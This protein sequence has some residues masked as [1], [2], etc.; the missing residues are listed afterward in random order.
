M[1]R[2]T[3]LTFVII[4]AA[5]YI[6]FMTMDLLPYSGSTIIIKYIG[7]LLCLL[8]S[9]LCAFRGGER[10]IP[11]AL[12]FTAIADIFLL[13]I[14]NY[15]TVGILFF[16]VVQSIYLFYLFKETGKI[17]IP[18]RIVCLILAVLI[19]W[20]TGLF[21]GQNLV[22]GIYFSMI[23]VNMVMSWTYGKNVPRLFALGLTLFVCC[24][25]CV[26]LYNLYWLLPDGLYAFTR[27][28]MWMF[29]LPSQVLIALSMIK[30]KRQDER[31]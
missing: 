10:L 5:L 27:I 11:I 18:V 19:L 3:I 7:I 12:I 22:A 24:D 28:G 21:N 20:L 14:D 13:V 30:G 6:V 4:E 29:Y 16:L 1:K 17:W 26:G 31:E 25:I 8:F 23:L 9:V 15:Y 2:Y